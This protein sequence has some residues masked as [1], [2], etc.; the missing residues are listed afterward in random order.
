MNWDGFLVDGLPF[1]IFMIGTIILTALITWLLMRQRYRSLLAKYEQKLGEFNDL[2]NRYNVL[3]GKYEGLEGKYGKLETEWKEL[4]L[5]YEQQLAL[6]NDCKNKRTELESEVVLIRP[7]RQ[8][9]EGLLPIHEEKLG[10]ID[11]QV[12]Q[13]KDLETRATGLEDALRGERDH[14]KKLAIEVS[15][16]TSNL[17]AAK[18]LAAKTDGLLKANNVLKGEVDRLNLLV[19]R[20]T[21]AGGS[22]GATGGSADTAA[23]EARIAELEDQLGDARKLA[24]K[25]DGLIRANN[26]LK[27][28]LDQ[29]ANMSKDE[30]TAVLDRVK[31]RAGQLNMGRIGTATFQD[32]QD[33]KKI[34]GIGPF[35]EKKLNALD[36]LTFRQIANFTEEDE[37]NV[38]DAIEFFPGRIQRD[39]WVPQARGFL[40]METKAKPAPSKQDATLERIKLRAQEVNFG[41]IGTATA[42]D[43]DDLKRIKGIGP[44]IEKKLNSIG[45]FTFLQISKFTPEDEDKVNEVIEFFP[46]RIRRDEWA[47]QAAGFAKE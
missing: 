1:L 14:G 9:Y 40:N 46:G 16:L 36:I 33:L 27:G 25:V 45:I 43:K 20:G 39:Q 44:F 26:I 24:A 3:L 47:R 22:A 38:T 31:K 30:E 10:L 6:L 17:N 15:T 4:N 11:N 7:F 2:Q 42:A 34:K 5:K 12:V 13:I 8:K 21:A 32:K 19:D 28:E 35:I 18:E 37:E 23:L 41:R 29:V